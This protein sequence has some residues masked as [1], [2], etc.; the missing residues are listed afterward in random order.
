MC[1]CACVCAQMDQEFN[2]ALERDCPVAGVVVEPIQCEGG[3][4]SYAH[5]TYC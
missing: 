1:V 2:R 4:V 5:D 3:V